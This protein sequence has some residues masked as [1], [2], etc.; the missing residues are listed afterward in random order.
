[1]AWHRN[2]MLMSSFMYSVFSILVIVWR[3]WK[4]FVLLWGI[5]V[6]HQAGRPGQAETVEPLRAVTTC[7][8]VALFLPLAWGPICI[9]SGGHTSHVAYENLSVE[10]DLSWLCGV[11]H[12]GSSLVCRGVAGTRSVRAAAS[13]CFPMF[14]RKTFFYI[15]CTGFQLLCF[16]FHLVD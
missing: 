10:K 11:G 6:L 2:V 4:G 13:R 5:H 7:L 12:G 3:F 1:M 14:M 16:P 15:I 8:Q 9:P